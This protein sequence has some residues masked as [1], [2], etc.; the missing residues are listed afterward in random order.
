MYAAQQLLESRDHDPVIFSKMKVDQSFVP[1]HWHRACEIILI[2][3]GELRVTVRQ[4]EYALGS[5]DGI[6]INSGEIHST[7]SVSGNSSLLLII[8]DEFWGKYT[9]GKTWPVFP[10]Y[11]QCD[12]RM[13][14]SQE[15][16]KLGKIKNEIKDGNYLPYYAALF[17]FMNK[18]Y[19]CR[20]SDV[21]EP[22]A[23]LNK[24]QEER[25]KTVE[26]YVREHY[27]EAIS[28]EEIA[29]TVFLQ[30]NYFC[31][32]FKGITGMSFQDYLNEY[33]FMK[34][35][36]DITTTKDMIKDILERHGFSNYEIFRRLFYDKYHCTPT[37]L[38]KGI[39]HIR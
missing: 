36:E 18:L 28:L 13:D 37:Q 17:I 2:T 11:S 34:V 25:L 3:S 7:V 26:S 31:R 14:L 33:R 6:I 21:R 16:G 20:I 1:Y 30:P 27:R 15:L 5:G 8:P 4:E 23:L 10:D 19:G 22:G 12:R 29:S 24:K 9:S 32:F 35:Y 38:R 39:E